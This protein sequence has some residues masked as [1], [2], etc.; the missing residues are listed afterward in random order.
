MFSLFASIKIG[1]GYARV[2]CGD[3]RC[4]RTKHQHKIH[5][6]IA[7]AEGTSIYGVKGPSLFM[8][9]PTFLTS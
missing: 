9:V 8:L 3:K 5:A 6:K 1:N 4:A 2:Y 7:L